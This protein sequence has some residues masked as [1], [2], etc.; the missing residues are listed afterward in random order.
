MTLTEKKGTL[1]ISNGEGYTFEENKKIIIDKSKLQEIDSKYII[2]LKVTPSSNPMDNVLYTLDNND[3]TTL[4]AELYGKVKLNSNGKFEFNKDLEVGKTYK[5]KASAKGYETLEFEIVIENGT[6]SPNPPSSDEPQPPEQQQKVKVI[7]KLQNGGVSEKNEFAENGKS[8]IEKFCKQGETIT[9][10]KVNFK[11]G[12]VEN[13]S[14]L[15]YE[16]GNKEKRNFGKGSNVTINLKK[17][18]SSVLTII[19]GY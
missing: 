7:F 15:W 12:G 2:E 13:T 17:D 14:L 11:I 9:V 5:A 3:Q 1:I 16:E 18:E 10:P 19:G 4:D 8:I 6:S